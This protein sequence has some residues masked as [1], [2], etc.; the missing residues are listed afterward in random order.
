MVEKKYIPQSQ[1]VM[2]YLLSFPYVVPLGEAG[3]FVHCVCLLD[4]SLR[5][6][7]QFVSAVFMFLGD[8]V[9]EGFLKL[10]ANNEA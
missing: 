1:I 8:P 7:L 5:R 9:L 6:A 2:G 3:L 4:D 10:P